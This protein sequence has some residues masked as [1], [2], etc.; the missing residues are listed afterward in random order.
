MDD[1]FIMCPK[2]GN[3]IELTEAITHQ[4]EEALRRD[5]DRALQAKDKEFDERLA[6]E[7]AQLEKQAKERAEESVT[8][9]LKDLRAQLDERSQQLDAARKQE[10]DL[11]KR[12]R[13]LEEREKGQDLELARKLDEE[14]QKIWQ[15]AA[16]KNSEQ[17]LLQIREKDLQMAQL[18]EQIEELKKHADQGPQNRQGEAQEL[19]LED[20]LRDVF[21][22]DAIEPVAKGKKGADVLQRVITATGRGVGAILWESKRTRTWGGDWIA[23]LKDDQRAAAAELAVIVSE[24]LP[25]GVKSIGYLDGI[26]VTDFHSFVGLAIALRQS[27]VEIAQARSALAGQHGKMEMLYDFLSGPQFRQRI[28]ALVEGFKAQKEDLDNERRA[29]ERQWAKREKQLERLVRNT[30]GLYGDLQGIIGG[31]LPPVAILELTTGEPAAKAI[32]ESRIERAR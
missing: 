11:R 4:F 32:E 3:Q 20:T 27:L 13:E 23:K 5:F 28:E 21:R 7:S 22:H 19:A 8:V 18:R 2:C 25:E 14:R 17:H 26:W 1:K 16:A 30:A 31:S 9:E 15:E 10:L 29:M 6:E 12:Q 24:T